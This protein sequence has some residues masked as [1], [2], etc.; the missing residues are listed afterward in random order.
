MSDTGKKDKGNTGQK[1]QRVP[2]SR[3]HAF[4]NFCFD[5]YDLL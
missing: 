4:L 5:E 1:Y 3:V 2:S